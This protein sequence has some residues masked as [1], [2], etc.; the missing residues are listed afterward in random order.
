MSAVAE[1]LGLARSNLAQRT[2]GRP[3]QRKG[4]PPLPEE[5]LPEHQ[6]DRRRAADLWLS[7]C[8]GHSASYG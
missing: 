4:R 7:P 3:P 1:T 8:L 6:S 2:A 5:D